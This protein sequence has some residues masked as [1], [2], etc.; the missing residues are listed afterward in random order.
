MDFQIKTTGWVVPASISIRQSFCNSCEYILLLERKKTPILQGAYGEKRSCL[1]LILKAK[2]GMGLETSLKPPSV[3]KQPKSNLGEGGV[4]Q[5]CF[6]IKSRHT[7]LYMIHLGDIPIQIHACDGI[8]IFL[9]NFPV[10]GMT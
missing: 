3:S 10:N 4:I 2:Q 1:T 9:S 7:D 8:Y 6:P 5:H